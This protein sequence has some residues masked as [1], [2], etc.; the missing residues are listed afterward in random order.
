MARRPIV[1]STSGDVPENQPGFVIGTL[2][3]SGADPLEQVSFGIPAVRSRFEIVGSTLQLKPDSALNFE[4]TAGGVETVRVRVTDGSG[5]T[6]GQTLSFEVA[7]VNERPT[8]LTLSNTE[9]EAG[10]AGAGVGTLA[11]LDPDAGDSLRFVVSDTRFEVSGDT[12]KLRDGVALGEETVELLVRAIDEGVLARTKTFQIESRETDENGA[13][14]AD[15]RLYVRD[16]DTTINVD[17]IGSAGDP[18]GLGDIAGFE[19]VTMPAHGAITNFEPVNGACLYTPDANYHGPD[20]FTYRV[21]DRGGLSDTGTISI[22]LTSVF[23]HQ[24]AVADSYTIG[25]NLTLVVPAATGVLANDLLNDATRPLTATQFAGALNGAAALSADGSFT[26]TPNTGF[27]GTD[28]FSYAALSNGFYSQNTVTITVENRNLPPVAADGGG[29]LSEDTPQSFDLRPLGS[30]PEGD[31]LEFGARSQPSRG[32]VTVEGGIA[33]YVPNANANGTDSF[34][35]FVRDAG[36][37]GSQDIGTFTFNVTPVNDPPVAEPDFYFTDQDRALETTAA[38]HLLV[39]DRD[40][41]GATP[42]LPVLVTGPAKGRLVPLEDGELL[43]SSG[44]F[45]YRPLPGATGAD[46]FVYGLRDA[47]GATS[48]PA[49]VTIEIFPLPVEPSIVA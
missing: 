19:I 26:Y 25:K 10:E 9:V 5:R 4:A 13:P 49:T 8:G 36:G 35:F 21:T 39:N 17:L 47:F 46:T 48:G 42:G 30:D 20:S 41:D 44:Q 37:A 23:D 45:I 14:F 40:P 6:Y 34:E 16:E 18:D 28:T 2:S 27:V 29:V 3:L 38:N 43:G 7:D 11:A 33:T 12:L 32:S 24:A 22:S 1:L 15:D 31:A